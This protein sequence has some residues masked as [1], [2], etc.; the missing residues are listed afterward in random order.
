MMTKIDIIFS[1]NSDSEPP[2]SNSP[3]LNYRN[4]VSKFFP[5]KPDATLK[6]EIKELLEEHQEHN[7]NAPHDEESQILQNV[8]DIGDVRVADVMTARSEIAAVVE[9]ISFGQLRDYIY[10]KEHTRIPVYGENLDDIKGFI[11]VKDLFKYWQREGEFKVTEILREALFV[12]PSMKILPLL[13]KMKISRTHVALVVDEYG[14]I[15]GLATIEDLMEEIVGEIEDEHDLDRSHMKKITD[16]VFE[17]EARVEIARVEEELAVEIYGEDEPENF[18]TIGGLIFVTLGR[19]A[20]IG[21]TVE[22]KSGLTFK[23][24]DADNRRIKRVKIIQSPPQIIKEN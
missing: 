4:F 8:I 17:A 23:V 16:G 24:I 20:E 5:K 15:D 2:G 18:D 9:T 6:S 21:D 11:H 10:E 1:M 22:H 3:K 7:G 14:G 13:E 19:V 12:P